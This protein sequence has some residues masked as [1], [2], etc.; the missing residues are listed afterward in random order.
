LLHGRTAYQL[1]G[2]VRHMRQGYVDRDSTA[3]R[4]QVLRRA[5]AAMPSANDAGPTADTAVQ[6]GQP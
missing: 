1:E 3:S 6:R 5:L 2:G 4:R